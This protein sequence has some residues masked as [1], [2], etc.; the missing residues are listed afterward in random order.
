ML[1][2]GVYGPHIP[3][4]RRDF[5]Q[6][7]ANMRNLYLENLWVVGGDFNM[8]ISLDEKKGGMRRMDEDMEA[9]GDIISKFHLVDLPT[10]NGVHS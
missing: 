10:I 4:E 9:F 3:G 5:L 1:L 7:L 6:K 2:T 8:I